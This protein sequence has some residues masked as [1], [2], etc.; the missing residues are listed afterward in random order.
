V[1]VRNS[2]C[3]LPAGV[4]T[5]GPSTT[6]HVRFFVKTH[7]ANYQ[8]PAG[9][10]DFYVSLRRPTSVLRQDYVIYRAFDSKILQFQHIFLLQICDCR[11]NNSRLNVFFRPVRQGII[12]LFDMEDL[13]MAK[14]KAVKTQESLV[15]A[16]KV[17]AY[18]KSKK[19]MTSSD[20]IDALNKA[21]Y[22]ILDDGIA[23]TQAN[24][25]ST[26]KAQDL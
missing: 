11:V 24:R 5:G 19:M 22:S 6:I 2:T 26:V 25:R 17:K 9:F 23:R 4:G 21:V 8:K 10:A 18:I 3:R 16:S 7:T 20:A 14:R 12:K 13:E 15:V 1:L